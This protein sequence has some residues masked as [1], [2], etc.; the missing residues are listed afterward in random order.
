MRDWNS[1]SDMPTAARASHSLAAERSPRSQA[2]W[3]MC[4]TRVA[5]MPMPPRLGELLGAGQRLVP[6]S[7]QHE[8]ADRP[9][10]EHALPYPVADPA[11]ELE[12]TDAQ[13][14]GLRVAVGGLQHDPQVVVRPQRSPM[15]LVGERELECSVEQNAA[16]LEPV[17]VRVENRLARQRLCEDFGQAQRFGELERHLE[18][19]SGAFVVLVQDEEAA[20]LRGHSATPVRSSPARACSAS[21]S[22][23]TAR[24]GWPSR[25]SM[26]ASKEE[27]RACRRTSPS[28]L[29]TAAALSRSARARASGPAPGH[30]ARLLVQPRLR[31]AVLRE[32]R[33]LREVPLRLLV[34]AERGGALARPR[35]PVA[36]SRPDRDRVASRRGPPRR[37]RGSARRRPRHSSSLRPALLE[38]G[39]RGKVP[40]L[41]VAPCESVS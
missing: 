24:G 4:V 26:S 32:L 8:R 2:I 22:R 20:E 16:L 11:R 12:R 10:E 18:A 33:G 40:G 30:P 31:H 28:A 35:E 37:R 41:A 23:A 13:L 1:S 5:S 27:T 14:A 15:Q 29:N 21:S 25:K 36:G 17:L 9:A 6:A 19:R 34:R 38:V 7:E 39:G 3:T